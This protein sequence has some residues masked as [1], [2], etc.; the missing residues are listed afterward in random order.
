[1]STTG[2]VIARIKAIDHRKVLRYS[3]V[4]FIAVPMTQIIL[5]VFQYGLGW[6]GLEANFAAVAITVVPVYVLNRY[7]VWGKRDKNNFLT[8]ILPFWGMTLLGLIISTICVA[9]ADSHFESPLAVNVA[10][11]FGFGLVWVL[12]FAVLDRLMFGNENRHFPI[13]EDVLEEAG[14]T[15]EQLVA[16]GFVEGDIEAKLA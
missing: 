1:M 7:W 8:E 13:P 5:I 3:A 12:K 14:V 4:S 16:D 15:E 11:A 10:N 6:N 9:Y 2:E